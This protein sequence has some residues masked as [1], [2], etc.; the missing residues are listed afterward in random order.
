MRVDDEHPLGVEAERRIRQRDEAAEQQ[1]AAHRE[2]DRGRDLGDD[3][4]GPQARRLPADGASPSRLLERLVRFDARRLPRGREPEDHAR[5]QRHDGGEEQDAAVDG[6]LV[7]A[8]RL[9]RREPDE[10]AG[11]EAGGQDAEG[12]ADGRDERALDEQLAHEA[13]APGTE[14]RPERHLA[15]P[16]GGAREQQARHVAAGDEQQQQHRPEQQ[17]HRGPQVADDAVLERRGGEALAAVGVGVG[18]R[19]LG[20]EGV[21]PGPGHV[22]GDRLTQP[23]HRVEVVRGALARGPFRQVGGRD[24]H[25]GVLRKGEPGRRHADDRRLLP[26]DRDGAAHGVHRRPEVAGGESVRHD[27][28]APGL[29][30]VEH[31]SARG[32]R[33]EDGEERGLHEVGAGEV[34]AIAHLDANG[35]TVVGA[36]GVEQVAEAAQ[37]GVVARGDARGDAR[38]IG[39]GGHHRDQSLGSW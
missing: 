23:R 31:P 9:G 8:R 22:A 39:P 15:G 20:A 24:P 19:E 25:R 5:R 18:R 29:G 3:E 7:E 11:A 1:P 27:G 13:A 32:R 17:V 4:R 38:P 12:S 26:V 14:R 35:A 33:G 36:D 16:G 34:G 21:E 37:V 28:C 2:D 6:D 10:D 30:G